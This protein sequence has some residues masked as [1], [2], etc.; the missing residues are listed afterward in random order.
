M[1]KN[2]DDGV[3]CDVARVLAAVEGEE[4]EEEDKAEKE[5]EDTCARSFRLPVTTLPERVCAT[6]G[7]SSAL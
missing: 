3:N 5:A 2:R 6:L 7:V 4:V 1:E